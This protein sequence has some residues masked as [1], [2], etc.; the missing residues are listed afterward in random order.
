VDF[1]Q[2]DVNETVPGGREI[3][4]T[5]IG[6]CGGRVIWQRQGLERRVKIS[7]TFSHRG[8]QRGSAL[9]EQYSDQITPTGLRVPQFA[10]FSFV[11]Q[12]SW[13]LPE[14]RESYSEVGVPYW[15][16]LVVSAACLWI[17]WRLVRRDSLPAR[18]R[19]AGL[20][21]ACGYDLRG[22]PQRCPECGQSV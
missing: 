1:V 13:P 2:Y 3:W 20:C 6:S 10:G 4:N 17:A 9:R 22:S 18:R 19:A 11:R 14:Q 7:G 15:A 5:W 16:V 8:W 21:A 12:E